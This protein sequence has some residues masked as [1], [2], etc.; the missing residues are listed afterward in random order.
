MTA[1]DARDPCAAGGSAGVPAAQ[2]EW[3]TRIDLAACYRLC[4]LHGWDDLI[5]TQISATLEH[6]R[7]V[8]LVKRPGQRF[9][10]VT[11]SSL[12]KVAAGNGLHSAL[13]AG[14]HPYHAALHAA[15]PDVGCVMHLHNRH[16]IAVGMQEHGLLPL[17]QSALR[18][19]GQVAYHDYEGAQAGA[20]ESA[21]LVT[22][23]RGRSAMLLRHHGSL[24]CAPSVAQAFLLMETL[25]S[26]CAIQLMAQASGTPL[27]CP[28]PD[29]CRQAQADL[30]GDTALAWAALLR[31]L[32]GVDARYRT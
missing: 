23:L 1:L 26:A 11:A 30:A 29:V 9:D 22:R 8:V 14:L 21:R 10:E 18:L 19:Y 2:T 13:H 7:G 32:D 17:S 31:K 27:H 24:V 5:Y 20:L 16:A 6:D 3:Q 12:I 25:D 4:A 15:R 28:A